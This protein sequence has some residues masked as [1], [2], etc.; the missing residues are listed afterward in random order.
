MSQYFGKLNKA[1]LAEF[2][3]PA[4]ISNQLKKQ[5]IIDALE[6]YASKNRSNLEADNLWQP[7][8][9]TLADPSSALVRASPTTKPTPRRRSRYS[10]APED[11]DAGEQSSEPPSDLITP[12]KKPR[13]AVRST[14][15][16]STSTT[17]VRAPATPISPV[18][19]APAI[20][21]EPFHPLSPGQLARSIPVKNFSL[22]TIGE[23]VS[24]WL[25]AAAQTTG[26]WEHVDYTR[27][28]LSDPRAI[29]AIIATYEFAWLCHD[30]IPWQTVAI[31]VPAAEI[32]YLGYSTG[33]ATVKIP[34]LFILLSWQ[35]FWEPVIYWFTLGISFPLLS[36]YF[37]NIRK[38][39]TYDPL[40]F[41]ISKALIAYLVYTKQILRPEL[42][43]LFSPTTPNLVGS[44][45][46]EE[47]PLIGAAVGGMLTL[48]EAIIS[49]R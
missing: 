31:P 13:A 2:A 19:D 15:K 18:N 14:R 48:W 3:R 17:V 44:I 37:I 29:H 6:D 23:A 16:A 21:T 30:L 11:E 42:P 9:E 33:P 43:S 40:T 25:T 7:Y 41:S 8:F 22:N 10:K 47:T 5:D 39:S 27:E 28:T 20:D 35:W 32:P 38:R 24:S 26:F 36:S 1:Q 34:D 46:G 45:I 12:A 4:G 49:R